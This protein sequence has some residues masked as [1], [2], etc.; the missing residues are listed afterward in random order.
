[1]SLLAVNTA[2]DSQ[3]SKSPQA[4]AMAE[5]GMESTAKAS[6]PAVKVKVSGGMQKW[7]KLRKETKER[8]AVNQQQAALLA[9]SALESTDPESYVKTLRFPSVQTYSS[10]KK[11]LASCDSEWMLGFLEEDGLGILFESLERLSQR[12]FSSFADA[13]VQLECVGCVKSVMNSKT[14]LDFIVQRRECS[15]KLATAL[16]TTNTMVKM[17]VFELLSALCVYSAEGYGCAVDAL[18]HHKATKD[19]RHRFCLITDEFRKAE[20]VQYKTTVLGFINCV[21]ISTDGLEDRVRIRNEFIGLELLELLRKLRRDE[22]ADPDLE[23]QLRV[24]E[25]QRD[26]DE[27]QLITPEGVNLNS[28]VDVFYAIHRQVCEGPQA[29]SFLAILQHLLRLD[30]KDP[31]SNVIWEILEKLV[32]RATLLEH[33]TEADRMLK[34]GLRKLD[35][36]VEKVMAERHAGGDNSA[37]AGNGQKASI[38]SSMGNTATSESDASGSDPSPSSPSPTHTPTPSP[39]PP[40]PVE[41]DVSSSSTPLSSEGEGEGPPPP[42]PP[43][44]SGGGPPPP[45]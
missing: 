44:P 1:M 23:V 25:E 28:S 35:K 12:G 40:A 19:K 11:K 4:P 32:H 33:E 36:G 14:G 29:V 18:E 27:V 42:P 26:S 38:A 21:I 43:P 9:A 16:D 15:R 41:D 2:G 20:T 6:E 5:G 10:L 39:P 22:Y 37:A 13:F 24:F 8:A 3:N 30:K 34:T 45:P 31:T 7:A 17:Q